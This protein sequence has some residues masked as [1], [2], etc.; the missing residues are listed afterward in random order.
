MP[1]LL[2]TKLRFAKEIASNG[3]CSVT[4]M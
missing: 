4:K 2:F 3:I 1:L